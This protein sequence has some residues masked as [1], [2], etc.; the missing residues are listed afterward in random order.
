MRESKDVFLK[1]NKEVKDELLLKSCGKM[2]E[3]FDNLIESI[4]P[5]S[6]A[7]LVDTIVDYWNEDVETYFIDCK[8]LKYISKENVLKLMDKYNDEYRERINSFLMNNTNI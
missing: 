8:M 4:E 6:F 7:D 1:E 5:I 3:F 2:L